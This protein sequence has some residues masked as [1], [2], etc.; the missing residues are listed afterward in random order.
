MPQLL[1][2]LQRRDTLCCRT[3][4]R[5][6]GGSVVAL[7]TPSPRLLQLV[8]PRPGSGLPW[9]VRCRVREP[10]PVPMQLPCQTPYAAPH[11]RARRVPGS[12]TRS[13]TH[14]SPE[15]CK[16]GAGP[17]IS[18]H[19]VLGRR[20]PRICASF[21]LASSSAYGSTPAVLLSPRLTHLHG[22]RRPRGSGAARVPAG[23]GTL[24][25][26]PRGEKLSAP[27]QEE[28]RGGGYCG[29]YQ[30]RREERRVGAGQVEDPACV[31][32]A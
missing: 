10:H 23:A 20:E 25:E 5:S 11:I 26:S 18:S 15:R 27:G 17:S 28:E 16:T 19:P 7:A 9:R 3:L 21:S 14:S 30:T 12:P 2:P 29:E 22:S 4:S 24:G 31:P 8:F 1:W 6:L 32:G 13:P